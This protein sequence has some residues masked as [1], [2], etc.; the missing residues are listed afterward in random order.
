MNQRTF[1]GG[2]SLRCSV[3]FQ[4]RRAWPRILSRSEDQKLTYFR[5][6]MMVS[7]R[8]EMSPRTDAQRGLLTDNGF[9]RNVDSD[10]VSEE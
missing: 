8:A 4:G 6:R 5:V 3:F 9:D 10:L 1:L 7:V 2:T